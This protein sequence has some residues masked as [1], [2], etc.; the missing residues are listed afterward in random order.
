MDAD[1]LARVGRMLATVDEQSHVDGL[2]ELCVDML[3][4]S[5]ASIAVI[6][7]GQHLGNF[8]ATSVA[9]AAVT[10]CSSGSGRGRASRP[11]VRWAPSCEPDLAGAP[12]IGPRSRPAALAHGIAG[13]VRVPAARRRRPP[14][15]A[16]PVP[17]RAG[18]PRVVDLADAVALARVATHLLL[19]L[20]GDLPAGLPPRP[21]GRHRRPSR[22]RAPGDRDGRG[23]AR[24]R[25]SDRPRRGSGPTPGHET[26]RSTTSPTTSSPADSGSTSDDPEA[27]GTHPRR[28]VGRTWSRS[29]GDSDGR[30]RTRERGLRRARRH[31][32]R[33]LRR[34]RVPDHAGPSQ[35]R[36][37]RAPP[38]PVSSWPTSPAPSARWRRPA[39]RLDCSTCSSS[40]TRKARASTASARAPPSSTRRSRRPTAGRP[41]GRRRGGSASSSPTPY[42]C[43]FASALIGAVE[44]L[45]HRATPSSPIRTSRWRR[46][47]ADIATIALLQERSIREARV[48]NEQLQAALHSRVVIEQAKGMLAERRQIE[49]D[50]AF[51]LLRGHAR[52]HQPEAQRCRHRARSTARSPRRRSAPRP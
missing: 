46:A 5:G 6:G 20:E 27:L 32:G 48:L 28:L 22:Q 42:P 41:S 12:A 47:L 37:A 11:T 4:I 39:R 19:E 31:P 50:D 2:L 14:R 15:R 38:R 8:A 21:P 23:A 3:D 26:G 17:R 33:R 7:D 1:R 30:T 44:H 45:H 29:E 16:E 9:I 10:T 13:G 18:R 43:G 36:A 24:C 40:R 51:A 49:M 25:R 35:R 34:G 52:N